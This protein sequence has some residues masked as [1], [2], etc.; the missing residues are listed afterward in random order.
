MTRDEHM[1][2]ARAT[3]R[4]RLHAIHA[5]GVAPW[6][7]VVNTTVAGEPCRACRELNGRRFSIEDALARD[8]LPCEDCTGGAEDGPRG[9]C[10]C[11]FIPIQDQRS[12]RREPEE[13]AAVSWI[14]RL[15]NR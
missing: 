15:F 2:R 13:P 10:R 9:C 1:E 14:G 7:E 6:V 3:I 4:Q 8:I 12:R 11:D 5:S